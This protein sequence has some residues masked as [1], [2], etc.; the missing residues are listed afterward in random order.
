MIVIKRDGRRV[1]FDKTK[2]K[3]AI[4]NAMMYGSGI[5]KEKIA[6]DIANE[7]EEEVSSLKTIT[8]EEIETLVY[9][10]LISKKQKLTAKAYE[11]YRAVREYQRQHNTIDN[12]VLGIVDGT[13]KASLSENSNK[14]EALIS[15]CRDL[16]A[17]EVSKDI[18]LRMM[19]PPHIAQA[20]QDGIIH[21]H[22][23]GHYLNSSFNCCLV[24]LEDM[25]QNGTVI[26]GKLIE[27]PHSFRTACTIATQIVA[28]VASGQFGGQ[29]VS[30]SHLAPF[31][32]VSREKIRK[33]VESYNIDENLIDAIVAD[34]L[35][36]E[37]RDGVQTFQYQINTL[38]TSN[39]QSPFLS[40]FMYI[41]ENP[42]Y[43]K[44]TAMIIEE[45][46]R[47]RIQGM[48]NEVGVWTTPAFPKLLY[49]LD[50]NNIHEDSE[51]WK[52]TELAAK[53]VAKRM[54]PDF[55]SAKHMR[56]NYEGNV[57][58]CMGCRAWLSPYKGA[59]N[60]EEGK[61]KW[62]GRFNMGLTS[63][64]LAD[65][66]L[67]AQGD[68]DSFWKIFDER[69]E[70]C[71]ESLMLRYEKL[72]NVTSDVSPI[73]WQYGAI[74]RL[75]KHTPIYPLLQDGYATIT[76]GYIGVYECVMALIG[77]SHTTPEGEKLALEIVK[78]M[79]A[80]IIEWK[81]RTGLGFALYGTPSE[82]LTEK[83]ANATVRRWGTVDGK[84]ARGFLT[85]SYHVFVEEKIDAFSKLKFE[86]QFHP[87]SS[88]GCISYIEAVNLTNNIPA[89]LEVIKYI[90]DNIQYAE[91][92]TK[93][94]YCQ[95]CGYDGEIM[96]DDNLEWYCPNCGNRDKSKM[97]VVRRTC[98][99]LGENF[100]NKGRTEEIKNRYVHLGCGD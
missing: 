29:T 33:E 75:P 100:W 6:D 41:S 73:H 99:Y 67:S 81:R 40:V 68:I 86:S 42:E 25:L 50:E 34:R 53:C 37:I 47:Q 27:R 93:S 59:I 12:K 57:F 21:I 71:F 4:L 24:N 16:V 26:N 54:M 43:E 11:D 44:E 14:N 89:V 10:K 63:I 60:N 95:V 1:D 45:F 23:L 51:Y 9:T 69:L 96:I 39:G 3:N 64:N 66:G 82:S 94:D 13:N 70:L 87:I 36:K 97:N 88:G 5:T 35:N 76:L 18:S 98:G 62:Y 58:G 74:A 90:Y 32:R 77:Q 78:Y 31:V 85:N 83:F 17:E 52:I 38:Q 46:I 92:N 49:V 28:Q 15:T 48:K 61:Y 84:E 91:I 7:I 20:H 79:K 56:Q 72:K 55:I 65:C 2:I 19:L 8:I 80:K 30:V 22:D